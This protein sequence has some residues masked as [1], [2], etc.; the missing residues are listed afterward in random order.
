MAKNKNCTPS[1]IDKKRKGTSFLKMLFKKGNDN[2]FYRAESHDGRITLLWVEANQFGKTSCYPGVLMVDGEEIAFLSDHSKKAKKSNLAMMEKWQEVV[3][4]DSI[5]TDF[6]VT[7]IGSEAFFNE[8]Y[9]AEDRMMKKLFYPA[10]EQTAAEE[11]SEET[12]G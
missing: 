5:N 2:G 8:L 3:N 1:L 10:G 7:E 11:A 12:A 4:P 9:P 6:Y